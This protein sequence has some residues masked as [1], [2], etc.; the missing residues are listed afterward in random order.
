M[1]TGAAILVCLALAVA[2]MPRGESVDVVDVL[3]PG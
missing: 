2:V 1:I 3:L